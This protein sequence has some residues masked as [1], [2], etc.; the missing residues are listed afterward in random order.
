MKKYLSIFLFVSLIVMGCSVETYAQG[1]LL[2]R[3][4][5]EVEKKAEEKIFGE[6][7]TPETPRNEQETNRRSTTNTRGGGLEASVPDVNLSIANAGTAFSSKDYKSAKAALRDALWG[8]ELEI[9]MKLLEALPES[10]SSL[11]ADMETDKISSSGEELMGLVIERVYVGN[12]DMELHFNVGNN[13]ALLS[14]TSMAAASMY[15]QRSDQENVKQIQFQD[16][17]GFIEYD[18]SSG[19]SLSVPFGQ[20]S[21]LILNGINFESESAFMEA[22]NQFSLDLIKQ[23]LGVQ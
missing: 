6:S 11:K 8:V 4:Q 10:V 13:S 1:R 7:V 12:E 22:A 2:R 21:I 9:G 15:Q 23:K 18:D 3:L 19:Y 14:M 20:S 5:E 16:H 17:R